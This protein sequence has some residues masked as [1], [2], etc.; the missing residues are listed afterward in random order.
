MR[1]ILFRQA[2]V[3]HQHERLHGEVLVLPK[4]ISLI[5]A[6]VLC[7]WLITFAV[8]LGKGSY[9]HQATVTGWLE[10]TQGVLRVFAQ[11]NAGKIKQILVSEGDKVSAGQPL[12]IVNGDRMLAGGDSLE[13]LLLDEYASQQVLLQQRLKRLDSAHK[14]QQRDYQQQYDA[15][16]AELAEL[17]AQLKTLYERKT[18]VTSRFQ[19]H[20]NMHKE[21]HISVTEIDVSKDQLL[22]LN[23][24]IQALQR[25]EIQQQSRIQQLYNTLQ[26]IP[27]NQANERGD[28]GQKLSDIAQQIAQL[29]GQRAYIIKA[30]REGIVTN[31]QANLGQT[32]QAN[33]PLLTLVP[34]TTHI[35]ATL[36]LPV[37]AAG[38]VAKGQTLDIRYDAYPY[39]KFGIHQ[40]EVVSVSDTVLLPGEVNGAPFAINEPVYLVKASLSSAHVKAYGVDM[41]LRSGMTFSADIQLSTRSLLEWLLEPLYSVKGRL[42]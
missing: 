8:F 11:G 36:L 42:S 34:D 4:G 3:E 41:P 29:H 38:F 19:K 30:D 26:L 28:I 10:P 1:S 7:V 22:L 9:T 13:Q 40:G 14:V 20:L 25:T 12:L 17:K 33:L 6:A 39:Q 27:T 35:E 16:V 23:S 5:I 37:R 32:V 24:D 21:G 18:I 15:A 31:L 2:A